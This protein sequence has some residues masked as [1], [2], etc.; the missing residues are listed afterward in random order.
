[1][2]SV[3]ARKICTIIDK[4]PAL[5]SLGVRSD[6]R[7]AVFTDVKCKAAQFSGGKKACRDSLPAI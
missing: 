1:M 6:Y 5:R 7:R 4:I 2:T 3:L